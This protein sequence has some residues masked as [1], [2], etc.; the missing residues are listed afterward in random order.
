MSDKDAATT[1]LF[2]IFAI[3]LLSLFLIPFT[4]YKLCN[5]AGSDDVVKP[6]ELV[7]S[8]AMPCL[9]LS[10]G[11]CISFT[12]AFQWKPVFYYTST[13]GRSILTTCMDAML[14]PSTLVGGSGKDG[15]DAS[16]RA[17]E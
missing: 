13:T 5:A 6:W 8:I 7:S 17:T 2:A 12:Q 11:A 4:I 16:K 10:V 14:L 9:A 3:S 15:R 1:P